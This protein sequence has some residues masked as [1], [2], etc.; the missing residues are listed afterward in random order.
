MNSEINTK[1][2]R[3]YYISFETTRAIINEW[4][5]IQR[6]ARYSPNLEEGSARGFRITRL[7]QKSI[8]SEIGILENDVINK[9]NGISI[10][11]STNLIQ[12]MNKC[13]SS[14]Q[15]KV[16]IEREDLFLSL[17]FILR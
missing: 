16:E 4:P 9:I 10:N 15:I 11:D 12:L 1:P 13:R 8:L 14:D 5:Y 6:E 2:S 17:I 7:P 3:E